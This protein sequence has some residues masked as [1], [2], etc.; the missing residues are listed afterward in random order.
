MLYKKYHRNFIKQ[1]KIGARF[2]FMLSNGT[3][4]IVEVIKEQP[5]IE[6][7]LMGRKPYIT[8]EYIEYGTTEYI[9]Y[10]KYGTAKKFGLP[11]IY[12]SG[13]LVKRYVVQEIS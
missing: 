6:F 9:K 13:R 11:L 5:I 12:W 2:K 10:G 4:P 1:F 7:T 3:E 8:T